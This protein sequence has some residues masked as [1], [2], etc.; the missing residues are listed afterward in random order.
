MDN[1]SFQ[2]EFIHKKKEKERRKQGERKEE[3]RRKLRE[4]R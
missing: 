1:V 2:T 3:T 4:K